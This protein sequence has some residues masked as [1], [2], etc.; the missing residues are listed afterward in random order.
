MSDVYDASEPRL[1]T[2][3]CANGC[4][5]EATAHSQVTIRPDCADGHLVTSK[6]VCAEC[7][8]EED[9]DR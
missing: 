8:H 9:R 1:L 4:G 5:R 3:Y 6:L 2:F 7:Q